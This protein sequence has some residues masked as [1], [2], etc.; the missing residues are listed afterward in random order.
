MREIKRIP[1][2]GKYVYS[3]QR[4][5]P[6]GGNGLLIEFGKVLNNGIKPQRK[7]ATF[8]RTISRWGATDRLRKY[9]HW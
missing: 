5:E 2:V 7:F 6:N 3:F 1:V 8:Q 9:R 4:E